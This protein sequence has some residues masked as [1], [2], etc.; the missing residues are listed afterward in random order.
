[1][2]KTH[3]NTAKW[4]LIT[5]FTLILAILARIEVK[6]GEI[7]LKKSTEI[8]TEKFSKLKCAR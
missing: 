2:D 8:F 7:I 1:M 4:P 5:S 3:N 6:L